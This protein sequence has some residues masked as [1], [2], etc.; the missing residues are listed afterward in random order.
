MYQQK[1]EAHERDMQQ[2]QQ[3]RRQDAAS[4]H[5]HRDDARTQQSRPLLDTQHGAAESLL[6]SLHHEIEQVTLSEQ[7]PVVAS[8]NVAGRVKQGELANQT[9]S[10]SLPPKKSDVS[11]VTKQSQS[12]PDRL[13]MIQKQKQIEESKTFAR[14]S[15]RALKVSNRINLS[16]MCDAVLCLL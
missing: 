1:K 3:R 15:V 12:F 14:S 9:L 10:S 11:H 7:K 6:L 13:A 5:P 16:Y 4:V 8:A 2:Q